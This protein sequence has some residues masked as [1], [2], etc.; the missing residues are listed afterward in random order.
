MKNYTQHIFIVHVWIHGEISKTLKATAILTK[1]I[2]LASTKS[3]CYC[4]FV[5]LT[6]NPDIHLA[7]LD[8][9]IME[10]KSEQARG[11]AWIF[12]KIR[13]NCGPYDGLS[14]WT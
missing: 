13:Y 12:V 6:A 5:D 8:K 3:R 2:L 9:A 11:N 7:Y 10:M 1:T 14:C 4:A